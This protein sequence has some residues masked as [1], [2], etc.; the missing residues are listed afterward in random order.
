M[1]EDILTNDVS[2]IQISLVIGCIENDLYKCEELIENLGNNIKFLHEI[3]CIVSNLS[4]REKERIETRNNLNQSKV[5][6]YAYK[7]ILMPGQARNKCIQKSTG[8]Y[9]CFLDAS[10]K[11][12]DNW[13]ETAIFLIQEN[14]DREMIRG[15]TKYFSSSEFQEC[16]IAAS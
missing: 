6:F 3:I 11:P 16:L 10:T 4:I 7:E 9:I 13:I 8:K 5:K 14:F 12:Q 1:G 15:R 2:S